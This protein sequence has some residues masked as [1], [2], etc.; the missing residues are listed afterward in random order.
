MT[1]SSSEDLVSERSYEPLTD[2][3]LRRLVEIARRD[4]AWF[5]DRYSYDDVAAGFVL[6]ALVQGGAQHYLGVGNGIKDLD[7]CTYFAK[8]PGGP[9]LI[10]RQP[11][12]YDF[13]PS[14]LGIHP[15]DKN[16]RGR[17]VDCLLRMV[18]THGN[19]DPVTAIQQ[20]IR[21]RGRGERGERAVVAID[22]TELFGTVVWPAP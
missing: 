5:F 22:P 11:K 9:S 19:T 17:H 15:A 2:T 16:Y 13:G 6:T 7:V 8:P 14:E 12:K 4:R 18:D 20:Y 10:R 1:K 3:H 21:Q